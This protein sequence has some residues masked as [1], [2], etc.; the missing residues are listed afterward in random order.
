MNVLFSRAAKKHGAKIGIG[1]NQMGERVGIRK[2]GLRALD[3][4]FKEFEQL[5][6]R[7]CLKE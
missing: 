7:K 1:L 5:D 6:K 4:L 3:G 2:F